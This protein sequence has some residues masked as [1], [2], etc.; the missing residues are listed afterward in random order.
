MH[1]E[2]VL[3]FLVHVHGAQLGLIEAGQVLVGHHQQAVLV[4]VEFVPRIGFGE[5]VDP[6]LAVLDAV[7]QLVAGEGDQ[8]L[9]WVAAR[10]QQPADGLVITDG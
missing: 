7:D 8:R 6:R 3:Q 5:A 9:E 4:G 1:G 2:Y 10:R